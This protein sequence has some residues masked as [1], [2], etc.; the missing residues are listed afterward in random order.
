MPD[1]IL[2]GDPANIG[3]KQ[4]ATANAFFFLK[5]TH[6]WAWEGGFLNFNAPCHFGVLIEKE[7]VIDRFPASKISSA[8]T[9]E[10]QMRPNMEPTQRQK[11]QS[12]DSDSRGDF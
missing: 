5:L 6:K 9:E 7:V 10:F 2:L 8:N 12:A 4:P 1:E 11:N 3:K